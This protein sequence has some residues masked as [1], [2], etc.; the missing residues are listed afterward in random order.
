MCRASVCRRERENPPGGDQ[1]K[2]RGFNAR[3]DIKV[4]GIR[5]MGNYFRDPFYVDQLEIA[6]GPNSVVSG[7]GS[8][9]GTINF[10]TSE[11][12]NPGVHPRRAERRNGRL[13]TGYGGCQPADR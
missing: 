7:R 11:A 3:G 6:K 4:D 10:V 5:D 13:S 2:I 8:P 12:A 1:L 9:G